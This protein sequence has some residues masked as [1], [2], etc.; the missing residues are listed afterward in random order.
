MEFVKIN[1]TS[2]RHTVVFYNHLLIDY[3]LRTKK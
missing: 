1:I 2:F 3:S